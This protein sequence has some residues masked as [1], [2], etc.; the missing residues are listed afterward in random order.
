MKLLSIV[1]KS[2]FSLA[3][4]CDK[5]LEQLGQS[6]ERVEELLSGWFAE[7]ISTLEESYAKECRG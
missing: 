1:H 4:V 3:V 7:S 5:L 6:V 2:P